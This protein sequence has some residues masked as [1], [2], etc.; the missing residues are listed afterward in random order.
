MEGT[1]KEGV[2]TELQCL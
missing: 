2:R 1:D